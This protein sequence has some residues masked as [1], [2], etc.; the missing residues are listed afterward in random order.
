[1]PLPLSDVLFNTLAKWLAHFLV[2]L[3]QIPSW[4][5]SQ[6]SVW[7]LRAYI[8][9]VAYFFAS[10]NLFELSSH[11]T[12]LVLCKR[13]AWLFWPEGHSY[14]RFHS[15][16]PLRY[17]CLHKHTTLPTV[18]WLRTEFAKAEKSFCIIERLWVLVDAEMIDFG[19]RDVRLKSIFGIDQGGRG[20][21]F[22][23]F[24]YQTFLGLHAVVK[25]F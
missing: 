19:P 20:C 3:R 9:I 23:W 22:L 8:S 18:F 11:D 7:A 21:L 24:K 1:M 15:R 25:P 2:I 12:W 10:F 6:Q 14:S 13:V 5:S 4:W 16:I 17:I